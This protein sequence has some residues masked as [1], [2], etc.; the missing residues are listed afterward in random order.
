MT[1]DNTGTYTF[2][3]NVTLSGDS[4]ELLSI[5]S[6]SAGDA[7]DF[8]M[9]EG[10]VKTDLSYLSVKDSDASGSHA[11]QKPIA[12]TNSTDVSGNTDWFASETSISSNQAIFTKYYY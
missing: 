4:E 9:S 3:G 1:F 6:D 7:F 12:P 5:L 2:G 10:A 8:V 11:T